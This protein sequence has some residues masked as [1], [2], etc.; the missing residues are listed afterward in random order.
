MDAGNSKHRNGYKRYDQPCRHCSP[1][2]CEQ[3][4]N[5]VMVTEYAA[6]GEKGAELIEMNRKGIAGSRFKVEAINNEETRLKID[7]LIKKNPLVLGIF[8]LFMKRKLQ[9]QIAQPIENLNEFCKPSF[10]NSQVTA[11]NLS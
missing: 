8:N 4:N 2:Y 9:K 5:P 1:T 7:M 6:I 3:K 10:L 11:T